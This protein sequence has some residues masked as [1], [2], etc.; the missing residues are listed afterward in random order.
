[1]IVVSD[2]SP[3]VILAKLNYFDLLRTLFSQVYI[4]AEVR[5]EVVVSG[6]GLPGASEVDRADWIKTEQLQNRRELFELRE[7]YGLGIGELSAI[8]LAKDLRAN[9]VLLDDYEAR[10]LAKGEHLEV[11]G[12]LGVLETSFRQGHLTDLRGAFAQ[13]LKHS[14][15][16]PRLLNDRLRALGLSQ[17]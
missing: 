13:L 6:A 17:L 8:V 16:D 12:T 5:H 11:R 2:S 10:R 15:V 14:Y 9:I 1:V 3:L 4:S 7:R